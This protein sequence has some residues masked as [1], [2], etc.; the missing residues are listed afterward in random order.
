MVACRLALRLRKIFENSGFQLPPEID[1]RRVKKR[2]DLGA[3]EPGDPLLAVAPPVGIPQPGPVSGLVG[4]ARDRVR[5]AQH[6]GQAPA[7]RGIA[8][9]GVQVRQ[10]VR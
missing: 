3:H 10:R 6:E 5:A 9:H 4:P 7:L 2:Q 8:G 1:D